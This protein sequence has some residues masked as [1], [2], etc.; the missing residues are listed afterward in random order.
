MTLPFEFQVNQ[1]PEITIPGLG[2][3]KGV[4]DEVHPVAKF[5]NVNER[6]RPADKAEPW[7]DVRDATKDGYSP[8]Q[9]TVASA[10]YTEMFGLKPKVV[11][12]DD[13]SE[14]DCLSLNIYMPASALTRQEKLPVCVW[15]Y[16][17]GFKVG[18]ITTPLYD[19][20]QLVSTSIEQNRPM[21]MVSINY[22]INFFGF[23]SS[24]ELA[25]DAQTYANTVPEHLRRWYDGSVGNWG[26]L[27]QILG[28]EWV[29]DHI[30]AFKGDPQRVTVMGE[31]AGSASISCLMLIPECRGLFQRA[32]MQSGT[33]STMAAVRPEHGGQ[34]YFDYLCQVFDVPD[35]LSGT[36]K[37]ARLRAVPEKALAEELNTSEIL[38]FTPT[39]D[40][41][42]LKKDARLATKDSSLY[43][44]GLEWIM[45]GTCADEGTIFTGVFKATNPYNTTKLRTRLSAPE[46]RSMFDQLFGVPETDEDA[47]KIAGRL[48]GDSLFQYPVLQAS[49][50]IL[51]HP[52]C[53]LSR[54]YFDARVAKTD[55][56][57]P[58]VK[59]HHGIDLL[60]TFGNAMASNLLSAEEMAFSKKV[61][62]VWIEVV[63]SKSPEESSLPKV[64]TPV[65]RKDI[66]AEQEPESE[67][68]VLGADLTVGKGAV[69]RLSAKEA[70]F[71]KRSYAYVIEQA[72]LGRG[73]EVG[74]DWFK[75]L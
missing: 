74:I 3:V 54:Y 15:I 46:D 53:Q 65:Q 70:G 16:G 58:T 14:R 32:I 6:W 63:T 72:Q 8:P 67:A 1:H 49:E 69:E 27:D 25:L 35:N 45:M 37:V 71:W 52:F 39:L 48:I 59:A 21:I 61:Q 9:A 13:M 75:A 30:Q 19:C 51:A 73:T 36:E 42:L 47:T 29:R 31:S 2:K 66:Q 18:S 64:R 57:A 44:P 12:E 11:Y 33:A 50:A 7:Q 17:G 24:K 40:G 68:I 34:R 41:V 26:L 23:I 56:K 55:E 22:R 60:Y 4:L 38:F 28:L 5:L 10:F 62:Q 20:T 43:D